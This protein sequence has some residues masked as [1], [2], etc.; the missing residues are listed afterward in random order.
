MMYLCKFGHNISTTCSDETQISF[1]FIVGGVFWYRLGLG[2]V[3]P[4][5]LASVPIFKTYTILFEISKRFIVNNKS[6]GH[7]ALTA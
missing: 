4:Y 2:K 6:C 3:L 7:M 5:E 1:F